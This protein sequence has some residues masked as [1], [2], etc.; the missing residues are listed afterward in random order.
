MAARSNRLEVINA[1][2]AR[3]ASVDRP[4]HRGETAVLA[5]MNYKDVKTAEVLLEK[6]QN[7]DKKDNL[8]ESA[9]S[10]AA[11]RGYTEIVALLLKKGA[12]IH[13]KNTYGSTPLEIA[14]KSRKP[15]VVELLENA[16]EYHA[17]IE[18]SRQQHKSARF[19]QD[20]LKRLRENQRKPPK[21]DPSL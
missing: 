9:L 4:N 3:G 14:Q 16:A 13:Q 6:T 1:L 19:K 17:Q 7:I 15:E 20:E 21:S 8:G 10:I 12:N 18:Q 2:L 5:A 11:R